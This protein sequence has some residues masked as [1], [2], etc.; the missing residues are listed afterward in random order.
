[1]AFASIK[2]GKLFPGAAIGTVFL[3]AC[4]TAPVSV[5]PEAVYQIGRAHV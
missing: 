2:R 5:T 1:M 3:A 4:T